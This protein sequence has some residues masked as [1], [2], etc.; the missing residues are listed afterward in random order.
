MCLKPVWA[1]QWISEQTPKLQRNPIRHISSIQ[2]EISYQFGISC[3]YR[4]CCGWCGLYLDRTLLSKFGFILS[5]GNGQCIAP[6]DTKKASS[7]Y[8][9]E[10]STSLLCT[11]I[12]AILTNLCQKSV[13]SIFL[14]LGCVFCIFLCIPTSHPSFFQSFKFLMLRWKSLCPLL[15]VFPS[16]IFPPLCCLH[17]MDLSSCLSVN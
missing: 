6:S 3:K 11:H 4:H 13:S 12:E 10:C 1:V 8:L 5:L 16:H 17:R 14:V 2:R 15:S 9:E 7:I